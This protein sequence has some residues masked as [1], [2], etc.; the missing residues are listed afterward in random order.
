M[1]ELPNND[2]HM[3]KKIHSYG[4]GSS[5]TGT[6]KDACAKEL[7]NRWKLYIKEFG[8]S[9]KLQEILNDDELRKI[10]FSK[11]GWALDKRAKLISR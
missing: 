11:F 3:M 6:K 8:I 1:L 5:F 9:S 10:N 7:T 4:G 2:G